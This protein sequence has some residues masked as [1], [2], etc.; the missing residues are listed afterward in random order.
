M[1]ILDSGLRKLQVILASPKTTSDCPLTVHYVDAPAYTPASNNVLT[2]GTTVVD[3]LLHPGTAVTRHVK[4]ITLVNEDTVGCNATI[5]YND[6]ATLRTLVKIALAVGDNLFY[7]DGEGWRV[8]D[9]NGN[10]KFAGVGATGAIGPQGTVGQGVP[11]QSGPRGMEGLPGIPGVVGPKGLTGDRGAPGYDGRVGPWGQP[12]PSGPVGPAGTGAQGAPGNMGPPGTDGRTGPI[13][14]SF[15][16]PAG[17][18]GIQGIQGIP[19]TG[20]SGGVAM[21]MPIAPS[22]PGPMGMIGPPGPIDGTKISALTAATSV[23]DADEIP[24]NEAGTTK[25]IT[26]TLVK[27]YVGNTII[28]Q[29]TADQ[30]VGA[31]VTNYITNS[32][33]AVPVG[34]L[35][36]GSWFRWKFWVD[37]TAA[38]TVALIF[39][40]KIGTLG[41]TGDTTLFTITLGVGT[42]AVDTGW[43]DLT[44]I[45]RGPLSS[46]GL[47][48]LEAMFDH[49]L[50]TTGINNV[51]RQTQQTVSSAFDVTTA[52][53]ILGLAVTT[54]ASWALTFRGITG[55]A[56]NI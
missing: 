41:T 13:G 37:K 49:S 42:A 35:R 28:N 22:I 12:G 30:A 11:G 16:G 1:I 18:Q 23:L 52:S 10:T 6:N 50:A 15:P 45:C 8:V 2:N 47:F 7:T 34:K 39:L 19:G 32:S 4:L 56:F 20:G 48:L 31:S 3:F 43:M 25:K 5:R 44:V 53:L 51:Q 14:L 27:A 46:S 26:G 29:S 54:G 21:L 40:V 55:E 36:I 24:V 38:G 17:I 33:L 9:A